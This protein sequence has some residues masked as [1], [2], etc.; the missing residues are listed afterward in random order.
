MKNI[1]K[2][3]IIVPLV[4]A[5]SEDLLDLEPKMQPLVENYYKDEDDALATLTSCYGMLT[6]M[7]FFGVID[8]GVGQY[9]M[10]IEGPS[11]DAN[12]ENTK[13][14][15]LTFTAADVD[16][17]GMFMI[18][19]NG[20]HRC[21]KLLEVLP[22]IEMSSDLKNRI[23]GEA[24]FLRGLY[25]WFVVTMWGDMPIFDRVQ[26]PPDLRELVRQP[27]A[28]VWDFIEENLLDAIEL[29]PVSY[30]DS[31]LGRAT[32]GAAQGLLG[33]CYLYE[34]QYED[35][36][37]MFET[38]IQSGNYELVKYPDQ[39][40]KDSAAYK[41]AF[42]SIF[43]PEPFKGYKITDD[44]PAVGGE[45]NIESLFEVQLNNYVAP[46]DGG[47]WLGWGNT[48]S[49]RPLFLNAKNM[50][51]GYA[52]IFPTNSLVDEF[53]PGPLGMLKDPRKY[54]T[55]W[56]VGDTL[57]YREENSSRS[58]YLRAYTTNLSPDQGYLI[59]KTVYPLYYGTDIT[60]A[61]YNWILMRYA[62]IL[63]MY[64]EALD[65]GVTS[66]IGETPVTLINQVRERVGMPD[67]NQLM[68]EKGWNTTDAI[69]H[70]RRI[71]LAYECDRFRDLV[72]WHKNGYLAKKTFGKVI[73]DYISH[74]EVGKNEYF[75]IPIKE[76]VLTEGSLTQ[77][78]GY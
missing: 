33:K 54:A 35:A 18:C 45:N 40:H 29:L 71:E 51:N 15:N 14:S 47:P 24:K 23:T 12:T 9:F 27:E 43:M 11:D 66:N 41:N 72:R 1:Y 52:N 70:E 17:D 53:E 28:D 4:L 77:N 58:T 37:R 22:D 67:V 63:L 19:F 62:D 31:D 30:S 42:Q 60:V 10:L 76:I 26:E 73:T 5:C 25:Y 61:E 7:E 56:D 36:A 75:P 46:F 16:V 69:I 65:N 48:G 68:A 34:G 50:L 32:K 20:I 55:V 74:F 57:E 38:V 8:E 2:I 64:A 3:L 44:R 49:H 13:Y 59:K 78:N 21:N 6:W 39:Y